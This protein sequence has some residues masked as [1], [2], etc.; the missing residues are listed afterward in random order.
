MLMQSIKKNIC[1]LSAAALLSATALLFSAPVYADEPE[2]TIE[3]VATGQVSTAA[4]MASFV[5]GVETK[6]DKAEDA[7]AENN[8]ITAALYKTLDGLDIDK[9]NIKTNNFNIYQN[10]EYPEN[11]PAKLVGFGV[12]HQLNIT[13]LPIDELGEAIDSLIESGSTQISGIT[14]YAS[15]NQAL[16]SQARQQAVKNAIEKA[17]EIAKAADVKLDDIL[18]IEELQNTVYSPELRMQADAAS[19]SS[20]TEIAAG[21]TSYSVSVKLRYSI[22]N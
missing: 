3:V 15:D 1:N 18:F 13:N 19:F 2:A 12:N 7:L 5:V 8:K 4:D 16:V 21:E 20:A 6:S 10:Y 17:K 14:F 11:K 9:E 22:D